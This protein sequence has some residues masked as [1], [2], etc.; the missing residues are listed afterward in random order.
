LWPARFAGALLA[1]AIVLGVPAVHRPLL[2]AAGWALVSQDPVIEADVIAIAVDADGAGVLEA[3]DLVRSGVASRVAVFSGPPDEV[4]REFERRGMPYTS[5]GA[6]A[7]EQLR[8]LGV[9][10]SEVIPQ[11]VTGTE[12]EGRALPQWCR[13]M[14][15]HTAVFVSTADHSRRTRRVLRRTSQGEDPR[16]VLRYSR[17]SHF[18]PD[19]WWRT[20][21]GIRTEIVESQKLLLEIL[22]HPLSG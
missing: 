3:V 16:I 6:R 20:R 10:S 9:P 5:P 13:N 7:V 17:Y 18:D 19:T 21:G 2:R 15:Y 11:I 4:S 12:D 22:S 14:G 1:L 8:T